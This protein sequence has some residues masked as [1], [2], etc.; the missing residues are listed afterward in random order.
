MAATSRRVT[1]LFAMWV[2]VITLLTGPLLLINPLFIGW[3]Q[4]R[5]DVAE[6]LH[7]PQDELDRINGQIVWD[8]VSGGE[9]DVA[10]DTGQPVLDADERSHMEDV[11][12]LVRIVI[13]LEVVALG[14]AA[15]GGRLMRPEPRRLGRML[16]AGSGSVGVAVLA[17]G[18]FAIVAWDTAFTLFHELLF[19]AGTWSFPPDSTM[20]L[21]YPPDFWFDAAMIAA[22]LILATAATLS[23]AGWQR[24]RET[25]GA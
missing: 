24:I 21:L 7:I 5:H 13:I 1:W 2:G 10:F 14:F 19:P 8:I 20:I 3:L 11:S 4:D 15:W 9:F 16:I 6:K 12:R 25:E 17:I 22:G 18:F 23:F